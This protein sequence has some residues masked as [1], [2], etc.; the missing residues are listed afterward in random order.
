MSGR[1]P[2][3]LLKGVGVLLGPPVEWDGIP[4]DDL[5]HPVRDG[6][7]PALAHRT[8]DVDE[9]VRVRALTGPAHHASK[10]LLV[11]EVLEAG[12]LANGAADDCVF[13]ST[14][15][16]VPADLGTRGAVLRTE[17]SDDSGLI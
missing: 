14:W 6:G 5:L 2:Q 16:L 10:C 15:A 11:G 8:P 13:Q 7:Q 3:P 9:R 4:P 17:R 12:A 1:P